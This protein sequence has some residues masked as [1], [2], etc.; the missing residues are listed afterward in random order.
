M[1][2]GAFA[3]REDSFATLARYYDRIM[4]H[5]DYDRW[6]MASLALGEMLPAPFRHA[7]LGCGTGTLVKRLHR[8]QWDTLGLDLSPAMIRMGRKDKRPWRS[9]LGDLRALPFRETFGLITCLFDS[10]NFLLCE[11]E[12]AAAIQ[13]CGNALKPGGLF[14]FDFVTEEMVLR[15]FADQGW[16]EDN[17][18]FR[19][20][21]E[22][23]YDRSSRITETTI[24]VNGGVVNSILERIHSQAAITSALTD[25]GLHPLAFLDAETWK[26]PGRKT[27]RVDVVAVRGKPG[28]YMKAFQKTQITI[29]AL[30]Q[31]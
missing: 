29:Q 16:T 26:P 8:A 6:Y 1:R 18:T 2:R 22:N 5:V 12:M 25:A 7:D 9:I 15:H 23:T 31:N 3:M 10:I 27:I 30:L 28:P 19:T 21:W 20:R 14:Y 11:S 13:Q 17:G 4:A 24:Q